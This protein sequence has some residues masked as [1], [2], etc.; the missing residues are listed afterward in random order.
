MDFFVHLDTKQITAFWKLDI[1][2]SG[3]KIRGSNSAEA[4]KK[5]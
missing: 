4:L 3:E 5:S 1:F 2:L